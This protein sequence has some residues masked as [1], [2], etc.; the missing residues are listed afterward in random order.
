MISAAVTRRTT[1]GA[2]GSQARLPCPCFKRRVRQTFASPRCGM[3]M[4]VA[5]ACLSIAALVFLAILK[6]AVAERAA[7]DTRHRLEQAGWLAESALERAA[8]RLAADPG[9]RGETWSIPA[10]ELDGKAGAAVTIRVEPIDGR[11]DRR[12]VR[13]EAQYPDA[14][15]HRARRS[16]QAF[17]DV[18]P[19]G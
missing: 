1:V 14:P 15:H 13:V 12:L 7:I 4:F 5:I 2:T 9:Y 18:I 17:M 6:T 16:K 8:A 11:A 10:A 19:S 3:V